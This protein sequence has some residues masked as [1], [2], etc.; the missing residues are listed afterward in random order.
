MKYYVLFGPPGAG[1]GTQANLLVEKYNFHHVSTGDLLREE[2]SKG[3]DL[4]KKAKELIDKGNFVDDSIVEEMIKNEIETHPAVRGFLFDGFPRTVA[5]AEVLDSMLKERGENVEKVISI[6]ID[7]N[8]IFNR[9]RHRAQV[10]KRMDDTSDSIIK[11]R[12]ETYHKKTEPLIDFY[13]KSNKYCKIDGEGSI[14]EIFK[15]VEAIL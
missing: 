12:I 11:T 7:D 14:E 6:M 2:I 13:K 5:Q 15:R 4:G 9:I 8:T 1:K 3:S 10:E